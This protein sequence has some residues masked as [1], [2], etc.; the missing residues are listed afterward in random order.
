[1]PAACDGTPLA[2]SPVS[3]SGDGIP[4]FTMAA[5][6]NTVG[7]GVPMADMWQ[8]VL[9]LALV[10]AT[11]IAAAWLMRRLN[12]GAMAGTGAMKIV[13][14]LSVGPRERLMLIDIGG[15]QLLL[16]ITPTQINTLESFDQPVVTASGS[17]SQVSEFGARLMHA[18]RSKRES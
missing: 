7:S 5:T 17:P 2:Q 11:I 9:A 6:G 15:R 12:P 14:A 4:A 18:I 3:I 16:G 8:V 13:A 1:V 10:V